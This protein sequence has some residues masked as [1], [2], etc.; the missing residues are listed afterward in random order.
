MLNF[1]AV[2]SL[3]AVLCVGPATVASAQPALST[4]SSSGQS[5]QPAVFSF[6]QTATIGELPLC[7]A[8]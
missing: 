8:S 6:R 3:T 1:G 5:V 4:E 7:T 2:L